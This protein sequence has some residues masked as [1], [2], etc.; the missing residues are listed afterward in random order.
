MKSAFGY[1]TIRGCTLGYALALTLA[2]G[3]AAAQS[4]WFGAKQS[5]AVDDP[6]AV[7][8]LALALGG[9]VDAQDIDP[10]NGLARAAAQFNVS[11]VIDAVAKCRIALHAFPAEP[12][13]IVAHYN[14]AYTLSVLLFGFNDFPKTDEDAVQKARAIAAGDDS[15]VKRMAYFFLGSACE[16]GVGT[17]LD[18]QEA[19]KWYG[20]AAAAGDKISERELAQITGKQ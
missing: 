15:F 13:V 8:C 14:A 6:K 11:V 16:Y 4:T 9:P 7:A 5:A 10:P 3:P 20:M 17:P 1:V 18:P 2:A 12:K 19:A